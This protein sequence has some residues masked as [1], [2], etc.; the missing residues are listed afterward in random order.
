MCG[1]FFIASLKDH[2]LDRQTLENN[3]SSIFQRGPDQLKITFNATRTVYLY[4]SILNITSPSND[5]NKP[6]HEI[7]SSDDPRSWFAFNG[8][9]Y[10]WQS[11]GE[12]FA[13]DTELFYDKIKDS[14]GSQRLYSDD[15][16]GFFAYLLASL[17]TSS[18]LEKVRFGV[19]LFGEKSL[20]YFLDSSYLIVSSTPTA[21]KEFLFSFDHQTKSAV[22]TSSV[23]AYLF[24][25]NLILNPGTFELDIHLLEPGSNFIYD[26]SSKSFKS[27]FT[28]LEKACLSSREY[29]QQFSSHQSIL[30]NA[31]SAINILSDKSVGSTFSGGLDSSSIT[32]LLLK[33]SNQAVHDVYNLSFGENDLPSLSALSL[34]ENL[35]YTESR[36]AN[37]VT[38]E[39]DLDLFIDHSRRCINQLLSPLPTHSFPSFS[40]ICELAKLNGNQIILTGD[41]ADE[42][43]SGYAAYKNFKRV[44]SSFSLSPY[45]SFSCIGNEYLALF[46]KYRDYFNSLQSLSPFSSLIDTSSPQNS[47]LASRLLDC[48]TNLR[49]TSL[50]CGDLIGS[51]YGL[52]VRSPFVSVGNV[53]T[54]L[55]K[56]KSENQSFFDDESNKPEI[57]SLFTS[58]FSVPP[59]VKQ[60]FSGYPNSA[61][62][63]L[64]GSNSSPSRL[65]DLLGFKFMRFSDYHDNVRLQWKLLNLEMYLKNL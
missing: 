18:S 39:V 5:N 38:C 27:F 12:N 59:P 58:L 13:N 61:F 10:D 21:I 19:D 35:P 16:R 60:G 31:T 11:S 26:H 8:E 44:S 30:S 14:V 36:K 4:N 29:V 23:A 6:Y 43:Y 46:D 51:S 20:F 57:T 49:S 65:S 47:V 2:S 1:I 37:Y 52:E 63:Q 25:R 53:Y 41:G 9:I 55:I 15:C 56:P 17:T 34:L 54:A 64:L 42:I 40:I 24:S 62:L 48:F 7:L 45:S 32:A 33:Q 50:L 28:S 3:L 22:D